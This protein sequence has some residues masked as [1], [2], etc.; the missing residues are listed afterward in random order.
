[1]MNKILLH[2]CCAPCSTHAIELL[3]EDYDVALFFSNSNIFPKEEYEKR[4][5]DAR[6]IAEI[7]DLELVVDDYNHTA[8]L[9][10]IKGL[11]QEPE[12]GKRCLKCFEFNLIRIAAYSIKEGFGAFTTTLTIS[13]HKDTRKIFEIGKGLGNFLAV[14]FKKKDGFK[15]SIELSKKYDLYRQSYCGCEFSMR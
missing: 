8:W 2:V 9:E 4:L 13:P 1:M 6:K 11:E 14:D 3:K 12:R 5:E 10:F 15:R 7:H